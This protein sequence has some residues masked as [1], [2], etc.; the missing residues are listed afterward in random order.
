MQDN[1][2]MGI[3]VG[4]GG[5]RCF[6]FD[7]KGKEVASTYREWAYIYPP[8]IPFA[9]E[10]D[11]N[12]MWATIEYCIHETLVKSKL[13]P[14]QIA[15]ISTTS[16]REGIVLLNREGKEIYAAP[17]VDWRGFVEAE[18]IEKEHGKEIYKITG[19]WPVP[20]LAPCRLMWLRKHQL[21]KFRSINKLLMLSDW[22]LFKLT[23]QTVS[24]P[25][26]ASS[27]MI[28]DITKRRWSREVVEWL[29]IPSEILPEIHE[30]GEPIGNVIKEVA[31][32]TGLKEG[33]PV[34]T[35]GADTQCGLLGTAAVEEG[36]TTIVAGTTTPTQMVLNRPLVSEKAKTWTGA[37]ATGN[38]WVLE[39]NATLT[40]LPF[41]WFRDS[42]GDLEKAVAQVL[43]VDA[44]EIIDR[45]D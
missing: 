40:G 13:S 44:Y 32:S 39:S 43:K 17:N 16:Q 5:G 37:H 4:T 26:N 14:N 29:S 41:R 24:D 42:I 25:S 15:G 22:V 31:A 12:E 11:P 10:F 21:E 1:Y 23:K 35:G 18:E 28:F 2:L 45:E 33:T 3:D 38:R 7:L 34:I 19:R 9:V 8:D 27:S 36:Q 20:L 30:S 6:I